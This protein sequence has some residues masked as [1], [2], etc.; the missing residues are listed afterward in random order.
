MVTPLV[1]TDFANG[2]A[3]GVFLCAAVYAVPM[4]YRWWVER[5]RLDEH[6]RLERE[7]FARG[8]KWGQ[9]GFS[10]IE[11]VL[12]LA[13]VA[14]VGL[15]GKAAFDSQSEAREWAAFSTQHKCRKVGETQARTSPVY[16]G[17]QVQFASVPGQ[18]GWLCD[19]GI[20][21]WRNK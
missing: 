13:I 9:R 2:F 11:V 3:V 4:I 16:G 5:D 10:L 18:I 1:S 7:R 6:Q 14:L 17:K 15:I 19:D 12:V 8:Q 20:T 21:Y